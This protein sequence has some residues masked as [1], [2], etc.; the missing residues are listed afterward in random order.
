MNNER[1]TVSPP[2]IETR[3]RKG[4]QVVRQGKRGRERDGSGEL[5]GDTNTA[6][7]R[8]GEREEERERKKKAE[9]KK[10]RGSAIAAENSGA[11]QNGCVSLFRRGRKG[12]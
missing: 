7:L 12:R 9:R 2:A 4:Y 5:F 6:A 1:P 10:E 3:T 11:K 8:L